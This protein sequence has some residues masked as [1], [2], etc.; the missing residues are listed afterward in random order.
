MNGVKALERCTK[1]KTQANSKTKVRWSFQMN[2]CLEDKY[3]ES[4]EQGSGSTF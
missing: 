4:W 2:G 1:T 3:W